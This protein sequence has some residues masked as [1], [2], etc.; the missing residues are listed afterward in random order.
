[1]RTNLAGACRDTKLNRTCTTHN[2]HREGNL[3]FRRAWNEFDL[4]TT[5]AHAVEAFGERVAGEDADVAELPH[6][7]RGVNVATEPGVVH[8]AEHGFKAWFTAIGPDEAVS[9]GV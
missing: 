4:A 9:L 1:M 8:G 5:G 7:G 2:E 6:F 3:I